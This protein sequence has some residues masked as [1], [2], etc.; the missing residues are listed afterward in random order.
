MNITNLIPDHLLLPKDIPEMWKGSPFMGM[1][2]L[3]SRTKGKRF[4]LIVEEVLRATGSKVQPKS[5][6]GHD[7]RINGSKVE[8]KGSMLRTNTEDFSF[9]QIRPEQDHDQYCFLCIRP[10]MASIWFISKER[11][12]QLIEEKNSLIM[13][14]HLGKAGTSGT[15]CM[16]CDEEGLESI[17]ACRFDYTL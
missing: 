13:K 11:I 17:G 3:H 12:E 7:M 5:G 9:L 1:W 16:Y 6:P 4:E 15:Y 2:N 8:V 10:D 14:Q